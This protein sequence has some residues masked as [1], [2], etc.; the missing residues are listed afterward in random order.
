MNLP[1]LFLVVTATAATS[2]TSIETILVEDSRLERLVMDPSASASIIEARRMEEARRRGEGVAAIVDQVVGVRVLDYGGP[3]APAAVTVRGGTPSQAALVVDGVVMRSPFAM[4]MDPS[5]VH[6]EAIAHLEVVR[7]GVG[8]TFGDGA[9]TGAVVVRT[10][11]QRT[12][13]TS[14]TATFGSLG[15]LRLSAMTSMLPVAVAATFERADGRF[16]YVDRQPGLPDA[17]F[18]RENNDTTR[19]TVSLA[20]TRKVGD[21][22]VW[23]RAGGSAQ[24]AGVPGLANTADVSR[25]A[26]DV[27]RTGRAAAGWRLPIEDGSAELR[28]SAFALDLDYEDPPND[29]ASDTTMTALAAEGTVERALEGHLLRLDFAATLE[30]ASSSVFGDVDRGRLS[31]AAFDEFAFSDFV[32]HGGARVAH[33]GPRGFF[34][35]PRLGILWTPTP[36]FEV[37]LGAGRSL[38]TPAIDELYHPPEVGFTGNPDL[39]AETSW[40]AEASVRRRGAVTVVGTVFGR[41]ITDTILYLNRN[42]FV[43][44]P[45]NV[46]DADAIGAELEAQADVEVGGFGLVAAASASLLYSRLRATG[47]RLP[48]QPIVSYAAQLAAS[49]WGVQLA[50]FARGF[51]ETFTRLRPSDVNVVRPFL[52]IDAAITVAE[53]FDLFAVSAVVRNVLDD[54]A[55]MT[56]N[57]YPLPGR[58]AFVTLRFSFD[59]EKD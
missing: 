39:V 20:T 37:T 54:R 32:V 42:A 26:R 22:S 13:R 59:G 11:D 45:E 31:I 55:L 27:R 48:T 33:V 56:V 43:V 38:R 51:S 50:L 34:A 46:G 30:G 21:G 40:E 44:R 5:L 58:T 49:R 35:L 14:A 18:E 8:S 9:L 6:P 36:G 15:T 17:T 41:R 29:V 4:G 57:R 16:T 1:L 24:D 12:P 28:V 47:E 25:E 10:I 7:G 53:F 52:S 3:V 2:T 23:V 19:G